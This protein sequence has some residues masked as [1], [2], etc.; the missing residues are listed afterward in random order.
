MLGVEEYYAFDP[1]KDYIAPGLKAFRLEGEAYR[2]ITPNLTKQTA[3]GIRVYSPRLELDLEGPPGDAFGILRLFEP[4]TQVC[5]RSYEE[6]ELAAVRE[7]SR[8]DDAHTRAERYARK[9]A[10]LGIDPETV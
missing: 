9:L 10:E 4:G 2:D 6:S 5:L 1:L 3:I 8:A 7:K